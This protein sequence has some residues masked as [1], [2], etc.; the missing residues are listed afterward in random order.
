MKR[1]IIFFTVYLLSFSATSALTV[2]PVI[3]KP[4]D[5]PEIRL[6]NNSDNDIRLIPIAEDGNGN[7][8]KNISFNLDKIEITAQREKTISFDNKPEVEF[9]IRFESE[10]TNLQASPIVKVIGENYNFEPTISFGVADQAVLIG[11]EVNIPIEINNNKTAYYTA[12]V[13]IVQDN[14]IVS[15]DI[16][17]YTTNGSKEENI[18]ISFEQNTP[19]NNYEIEVLLSDAVLDKQ[20]F[21]QIYVSNIQTNFILIAFLVAGIIISLLVTLGRRSGA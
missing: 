7:P 8:I 10:N 15:K 16:L 14:K 3:I 13:Q 5:K 18:L 20:V 21:N 4:E 11:N 9:F 17:D 2:S 12:T 6:I 19:L 1:L